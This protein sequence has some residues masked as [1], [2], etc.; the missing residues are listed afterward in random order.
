VN[1][2]GLFRSLPYDPAQDFRGIG[3][4]ADF[5]LVVAVPAASRFRTIGEFLDAARAA[6][7]RIACGTAIGYRG[8]HAPCARGDTHS[9]RAPQRGEGRRSVS[10][11]GQRAYHRQRART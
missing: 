3:M 8:S 6:P 5:P 7:G 9:A 11:A 1:A 10:L 4:F 2:I